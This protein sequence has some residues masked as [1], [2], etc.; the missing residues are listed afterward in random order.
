METYSVEMLMGRKVVHYN[1][2]Y[3][4]DGEPTEEG[5]TWRIEEGCGC[6]LGSRGSEVAFVDEHAGNMAEFIWEQFELV[7]QY[8][9]GISDEEASDGMAWWRE[10]GTELH[11]DDVTVDTPCG[12]YWYGSED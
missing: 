10:N 11:M 7:Q 12:L 4:H 8:G 9:G 3:W 6:G 5:F 2:Y 1:G